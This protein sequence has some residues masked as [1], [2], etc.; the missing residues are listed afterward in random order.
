MAT[1][2]YILIAIVLVVTVLW[3][4]VVYAVSQHQ[5]EFDAELLRDQDDAALDSIRGAMT[6]S[7]ILQKEVRRV[8]AIS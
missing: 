8:R 3:C 4:L 1:L 6:D 2:L 5:A 7:A